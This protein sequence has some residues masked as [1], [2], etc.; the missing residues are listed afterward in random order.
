MALPTVLN[1]NWY[2]PE[3]PTTVGSGDSRRAKY[4]RFGKRTWC[5]GAWLVTLPAHAQTLTWDAPDDCP[6]REA[7]LASVRE[8]AGEEVV[9][10]TSLHAR[11]RIQQVNGAFRLELEVMGEGG[12]QLRT[13]DARSCDD[14]RG[15]AA[16]VLGLNLKRLAGVV[17]GE[18]AATTSNATASA[19]D[20][21]SN[22]AGNSVASDPTSTTSGQSTSGQTN[23]PPNAQPTAAPAIAALKSAAPVSN[24]MDDSDNRPTRAAPPRKICGWL[25]R[26]CTFRRGRSLTQVYSGERGLAL[27]RRTGLCPYRGG[28]NPCSWCSPMLCR[29]LVP[30][31]LGSPGKWGL[32]AALGLSS[33]NGLPASWLVWT[34]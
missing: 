18:S 19:T 6:Q 23:A 8:I 14:L 2:S 21:T 10:R 33:S 11:G 32:P 4:G 31:S 20:A 30:P 25:C 17:Q 7:V 24:V 26:K 22:S 34:T 16:V 9:R 29:G 27:G 15:A 5:L 13:I 28:T 12:A 3:S 1:G